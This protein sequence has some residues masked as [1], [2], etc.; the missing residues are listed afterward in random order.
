MKYLIGLI[1]LA[2][3]TYLIRFNVG[4]V[5]TTLLEVIIYIVFLFGLYTLG[6]SQWLKVKK[7]IWLPIALLLLA[8]IISVYIAPDQMVALGQVKGFFVDP[9]MV[10][11]L[12]ICFLEAKDIKW[13]F[14][15]LMGS[16]LFVS[17]NTIW[18]KIAGHITADGRVVGIY[19]Y[20]P[21]YLALYLAPIIVLALISAIQLVKKKLWLSCFLFLV[22][23]ILLLG[24]YFS[25]SRGGLLAV[26]GGLVFYKIVY[27]WDFIAK[28]TWRKVALVSIIILAILGAWFV[29]KP[30]FQESSGRVTTSN[31]LR[32][33]IWGATLELGKMNPIAG[34]GLGNFQNAFGILTN[35]RV[36]YPEFITPQ[37]LTPHNIFLMWWLST[38]ILGL[39]AFVFLEIVFYFK[40][41]RKL[42]N[43]I[44]IILLAMMTTI[45][46]QGLVDTP[47]FKNDLAVLFWLIFGSMI[48]LYK[49]EK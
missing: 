17:V 39:I 13:I 36:N 28:K 49:D 19:G 1:A 22:S 25:G 12:M 48:L 4:A 42:Q 45:L 5:P 3:P 23:C 37:A 34:V 41:L 30:D 2:L 32:W 44:S 29:F 7:R 31:N 33:Q 26:F 24:V 8:L 21:N 46:L 43:P 18:Q 38:G 15:G 9:L 35:N 10:F 14:Y 11:F 27:Y 40:G 20:S 16:G 47:Y 6:Y